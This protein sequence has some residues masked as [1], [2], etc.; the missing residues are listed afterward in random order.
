M[1]RGGWRP[2]SIRAP[3][4]AT[5]SAGWVSHVVRKPPEPC[6]RRNFTGRWRSRFPAGSAGRSRRARPQRRS[7]ADAAGAAAQ[8]RQRRSA[9]ATLA[10]RR[11]QAAAAGS[12]QLRP[13]AQRRRHADDDAAASRVIAARRLRHH[14][15]A[16]HSVYISTTGIYGDCAGELIDETRRARPAS[17]RARR[18]VAAEARIR[19]A[20]SQRLAILRA[21]ASMRRIVAAG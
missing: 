12:R 18:R 13:R 4:P 20:R 16:L 17:A 10:G 5:R 21:R 8:R 19:A 7:R 1:W 15:H 3:A 11:F 2:A 6:G 9:H 14:R